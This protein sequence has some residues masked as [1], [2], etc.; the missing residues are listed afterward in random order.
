M[1]FCTRL[2]PLVIIISSSHSA[3]TDKKNLGDLRVALPSIEGADS[4]VSESKDV[5]AGADVFTN[6]PV[7][8]SGQV[9]KGRSFRWEHVLVEQGR[10]EFSEPTSLTTEVKADRDGDYLIELISTQD[11]RELK[12]SLILH[13]DTTPP[14]FRLEE[15]YKAAFPLELKVTVEGT[16]TYL[17][18][19]ISGPGDVNFSSPKS[20]KTNFI[21]TLSGTYKIQITVKDTVGNATTQATTVIW[22]ETSPTVQLGSDVFTNQPTISL[23]PKVSEGDLSFQWS[24]VSSEG[25]IDF[26]QPLRKESSL[27]FDREGVYYVRL[28]AKNSFGT[29]VTDEIM[30]V[31]DKTAPELKLQYTLR[32][33]EEVVLQANV[34]DKSAVDCRWS[35]VSGINGSFSAPMSLMSIFRAAGAGTFRVRLDC[36]DLAG[37]SASTEKDVIPLSFERVTTKRNEILLKGIG[38]N[39]SAFD[40]RWSQI[41]GPSNGVL[42]N[43]TSL[44]TN[45]T[46]ASLGNFRIRLE[47]SDSTGNKF[48]AEK[49]VIPGL[50]AETEQDLLNSGLKRGEAQNSEFCARYPIANNKVLA[51]F[52]ENGLRPKSLLELQKAMGLA[53]EPGTVTSGSANSGYAITAHSSSYV[54]RSVSAINPRVILFA[55]N[56]DGTDAR[57]LAFVRGDHAVQLSAKDSTGETKLYLATFQQDCHK[58]AEGCTP[59]HTLTPQIESNW[60]EFTLYAEEDLKNTTLDCRSCHQPD[61][62]STRTILRMQELRNPWTHWFRTNGNQP[63]NGV[64]T[65][66]FQGAHGTSESYGGIPGSAIRGS[67]PADLEIFIRNEGFA[68]DLGY[69]SSY[70]SQPNEFPTGAIAS[71]LGDQGRNATG[72]NTTLAV[73]DPLACKLDRTKASPSPSAVWDALFYNF[74]NHTDACTPTNIQGPAKTRR[75]IPPP[76]L[77][78]FVADPML[79]DKYT[80][81]Y[82]AFLAGTQS[83]LT[84]EDHR[85]IFP[86]DP[87]VASQMGFAVDPS[88]GPEDILKVACS[89][90]HHGDLDK[91]LSR[92]RF[93][94]LDFSKISRLNET[95]DEAILRVKLGYSP[96]RRQA[97][98]IAFYDVN[99]SYQL[100]LKKGDHILAMPP[101]R[102]RQLT[103][104]QIDKLVD[105]F[106]KQKK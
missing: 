102:Y 90:C 12:D 48:P 57:T 7:K 2:L 66:Q 25:K 65:L 70:S 38:E 87:V 4:Q 95:M 8:L 78:P 40:C 53:L 88:Y 10:V 23:E 49:D 74:M 32:E 89:Q 58:A 3:C 106:K 29:I 6:V 94:A 19:K 69:P 73:R 67:D 51:A 91:S 81:Q 22:D 54:A 26:S 18:E 9:K 43:P 61:G 77:R 37:N 46:T 47:C 80:Q 96:A 86:E 76:Y 20:S 59:L 5:E 63:D 72:R 45:F 35:Q 55:R 100:N 105:Y 92:A 62:P 85:A 101:A 84:F 31:Y 99:S 104:E 41:A 44:T 83:P 34:Q 13:W 52:C 68:I 71:E 33:S 50:L 93:N 15:L 98:S 79:L 75:F 16:N 97:E 28:A 82:Q 1:S 14:S 39:L 27:T 11:N 17:W 21:A 56:P 24:Y 42:S 36:T 64:L 30:V 60:T 103:D